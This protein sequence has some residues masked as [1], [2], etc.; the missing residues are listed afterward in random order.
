MNYT[1]MCSLSRLAP[2]CAP[3]T[4]KIRLQT[5]AIN[6]RRMELPNHRGATKHP[7]RLMVEGVGFEPTKAEPA[8]LQSAP[9]DRLGT[10]PKR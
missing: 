1:R 4:P 8:D 5:S 3:I 7:F 6:R 9:V 10:P 2:F